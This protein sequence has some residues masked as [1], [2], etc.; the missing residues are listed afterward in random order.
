MTQPIIHDPPEYGSVDHF[1]QLIRLGTRGAGSSF[2]PVVVGTFVSV[3]EELVAGV[4]EMSTLANLLT[5]YRQLCDERD[6]PVIT[7]SPECQAQP[8]ERPCLDDCP[9]QVAARN[10]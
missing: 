9:A 6:A 3:S 1:V 10:S 7:C 4:G 2:H 5:A 8:E